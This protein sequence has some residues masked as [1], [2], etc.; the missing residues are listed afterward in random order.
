MYKIVPFF[1]WLF[2]IQLPLYGP[3]T[4]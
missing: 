1:E 3:M 2:C 4:C